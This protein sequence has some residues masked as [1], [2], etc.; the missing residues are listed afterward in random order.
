MHRAALR[1]GLRDAPGDP[2]HPAGLSPDA[3]R[4]P[5]HPCPRGERSAGGAPPPAPQCNCSRWAA[6]LSRRG[7]GGGGAPRFG[8]APGCACRGAGCAEPAPEE[9]PGRGRAGQGRVG[10][11][12]PPPTPP[13]AAAPFSPAGF[14]R[15]AAAA[16]GTA[17]GA[18][19]AGSFW[20]SPP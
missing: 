2:A 6:S 13:I 15:P 1:S 12:P 20:T 7:G 3:G 10:P 19:R 16:A 11:P 18:A 17:A 4:A 5:R 9:V 8:A 14:R